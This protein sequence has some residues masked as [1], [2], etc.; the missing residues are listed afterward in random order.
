MKFTANTAVAFAG[1]AA[2]AKETTNW[3]ILGF[4]GKEII[5]ARVDPIVAPGKVSEHVHAVMGGSAFNKD[6]TG[7]SLS[8]S[9][10]TNA[11]IEED[12]SNYWF[13]ALYF[14]DPETKAFEPVDIHYVNVYYL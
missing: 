9:K 5:R 7:E 3:G 12:H 2:A 6:S 14:Q 8:Q 10:C 1:L 11:R 4:N 13:P